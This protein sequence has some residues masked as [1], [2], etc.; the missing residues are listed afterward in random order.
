MPTTGWRSSSSIAY[1]GAGFSRPWIVEADLQVGLFCCAP[2][3]TA[4]RPAYFFPISVKPAAG[5]NSVPIGPNDILWPPGIVTVRPA[6]TPSAAPK[7]T[8]L[9]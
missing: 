7:A 5:P 1:V 3:G 8:S 6:T 2:G 9:R 4:P